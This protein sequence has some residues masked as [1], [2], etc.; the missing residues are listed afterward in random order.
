[1]PA[2]ARRRALAR[3]LD[4]DGRLEF[5]YAGLLVRSGDRVA[6][7][8]TGF[9]GPGESWPAV[10]GA[11]LRGAGLAP[12][13][14]DAVVISHGHEDHVGGLTRRRGGRRRPVFTGARH[15][16]ASAELRHWTAAGG[17]TAEHLS[18]VQ[19][20]GLVDPVDGEREVLPGVRVLPAPGH[21]PGHLAVTISSGGETALYVGDAFAHEVNV[22]HPDWNHFSDM[23]PLQAAASRR[24]LVA[25]AARDGAIVVA[26]HLPRVGRVVPTAAGARLV[27]A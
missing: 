12:A 19:S 24:R 27:A 16:V 9:P 8:D 1:M 3:H 20:A 7:L 17:A 23:L 10:L 21:T 15:V 22:P 2:A 25:R 4:G 13:G 14:V 5:R 18:A 6:L 26:S 11:A